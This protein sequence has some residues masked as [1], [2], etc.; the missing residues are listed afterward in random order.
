MR[1]LRILAKTT[2]Q[3]WNAIQTQYW[4]HIPAGFIHQKIEKV[5]F[6]GSCLI[7]YRYLLI[8]SNINHTKVFYKKKVNIFQFTK[9]L[10]AK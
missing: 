4:S 3:N 7:S 9:L 1:L 5:L 8:G 6:Y 2:K 10:S